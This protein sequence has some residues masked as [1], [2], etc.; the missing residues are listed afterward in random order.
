VFKKTYKPV[1]KSVC[2]PKSREVSKTDIVDEPP[3]PE[4]HVSCESV[5]TP[6]TMECL[7]FRFSPFVTMHR[8]SSWRQSHYTPKQ[9]HQNVSTVDDRMPVG[10]SA[11]TS[12]ALESYNNQYHGVLHLRTVLDNAI[13]RLEGLT[14]RTW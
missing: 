11:S 8:G 4:S 6:V 3:T 10:T 2:T 13:S 1:L 12:H 9:H 5:S 14:F 7:P